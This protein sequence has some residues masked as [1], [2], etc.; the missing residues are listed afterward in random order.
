[1]HAI[2]RNSLGYI[3]QRNNEAIYR[4]SVNYDV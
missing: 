1:M 2:K 4:I 3:V